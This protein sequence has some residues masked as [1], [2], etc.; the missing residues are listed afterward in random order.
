MATVKA[1]VYKSYPHE[2][3]SCMLGELRYACDINV[4]IL[5][6]FQASGVTGRHL[7]SRSEILAT[8]ECSRAAHISRVVQTSKQAA[9]AAGGGTECLYMW[10]T[11]QFMFLTTPDQFFI[12]LSHSRGV[13]P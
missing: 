8:D 2:H 7:Y 10:T 12:F 5:P 3:H 4:C 1:T 6:C 13:R 11:R 9:R